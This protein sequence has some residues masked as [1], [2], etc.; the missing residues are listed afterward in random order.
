VSTSRP[1]FDRLTALGLATGQRVV[2][3]VSVRQRLGRVRSRGWFIL[4]CAVAASVAWWVASD[5]LDK[6]QPF[7]APVAALICLGM[8][9]GHRLRRSVEVLVGV[10]VG[11]AVG[12]LFVTLV[13]VGTWQIALSVLVALTLAV[14]LSGS[15]LVVTQAGVQAVIVTTLIPDPT[16]GLAR[17]VDALIGGVVALGLATIAPT[18]PLRRPREEAAEVVREIAE[19]LDEV[20]ASA[21]AADIDRASAA[22]D[23]ARQSEPALDALRHASEEALAVASLTP[24]R[25]GHAEVV[26]DVVAMTEPLDHAI[27]NL[28][29]LARRVLAATRNGER[30]PDR[31]LALVS[32]LAGATATLADHL[33]DERP[34]AEVREALVAVAAASSEVEPSSL[35]S[36]QVVLAQTRSI[37]VDLLEVTGLTFEA[38]VALVPPPPGMPGP[39]PG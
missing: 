23:R 6:P 34:I 9:Y 32:G 16:A 11:V 22:L 15:V 10:A 21:L 17:W 31:Y 24:G 29:V 14:F 36:A 28:R 12:D 27:R 4:Q 35:L 19:L 1:G 8:S 5:L 25:R 20:V 13:G 33:S 2:E 3:R 7:F 37:V 18:S 38:A 39:E 26:R 30:I